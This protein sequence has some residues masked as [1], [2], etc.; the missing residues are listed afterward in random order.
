MKVLIAY[1]TKYG[2]TEK[3]AKLLA[4]KTSGEV[5]LCNLKE[6][7][8]IQLSQYDK[9][10]IGG[11]MYGGRIQK[12]VKEFC[13]QNLELLSKKQL[14]LF[15]CGMLMKKAQEQLN[16]SF[17]TELLEK[18]VA[19]DFFGGEFKFK[20]MNAMERFIVKMVAKSDKDL[21][22]IDTKQNTLS[23]IAMEKID[24]FAEIMSA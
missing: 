23:A 9:I 19:K 6:T 20:D 4:E 13:T 21:P 12:E 15:V 2:C 24:R 10:I 22:N 14:G 17:P 16:A 3:C 1:G 7:K 5:R 11:S 8:K 18:A